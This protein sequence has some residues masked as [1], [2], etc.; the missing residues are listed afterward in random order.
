MIS[1][2]LQ[3]ANALALIRLAAFVELLDAGCPEDCV[4]FGPTTPKSTDGHVSCG[5]WV[6]GQLAWEVSATWNPDNC[7]LDVTNYG[8]YGRE[9]GRTVSAR[10]WVPDSHLVKYWRHRLDKALQTA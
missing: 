9:P 5:L 10:E 6:C 8:W 7:T 2:A 1:A 3:A 4:H